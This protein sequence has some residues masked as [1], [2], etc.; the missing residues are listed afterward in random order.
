M[1]AMYQSVQVRITDF[2]TLLGL[3]EDQV[4]TLIFERGCAFAEAYYPPHARLKAM[5]DPVY[6]HWWLV[7]WDRADKLMYQE[8]SLAAL[9]NRANRWRLYLYYHDA[10]QML[11]QEGRQVEPWREIYQRVLKTI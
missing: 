1:T 5:T 3:E 9:H 7:Q 8:T 6:W 10:R 4:S 2:L 11:Q